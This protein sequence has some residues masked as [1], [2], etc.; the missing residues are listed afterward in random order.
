MKFGVSE[1]FSGYQ[2][3]L[4]YVWKFDERI[5]NI[6]STEKNEKMIFLIVYLVRYNKK[7]LLHGKKMNFLGKVVTKI[8]KWILPIIYW[9]IFFFSANLKNC[10][11]L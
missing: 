1:F 6:F 9:L 2:I 10:Y 5:F 7:N 11:F 8:S 4:M 3:V